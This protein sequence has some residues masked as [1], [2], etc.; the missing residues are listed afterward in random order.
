MTVEPTT[1]TTAARRL[2]GPF[3]ATVVFAACLAVAAL[4]SGHVLF[5]GLILVMAVAALALHWTVEVLAGRRPTRHRWLAWL[6]A[7]VTLVAL[8]AIIYDV[9]LARL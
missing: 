2:P 3:G 8:L 1:V 6:L 9:T 7:A 4:V 5:A